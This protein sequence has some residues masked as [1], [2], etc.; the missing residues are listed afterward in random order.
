MIEISIR[1]AVKEEYKTI[2]DFQVRMALE[3]EDFM[4]D[5]QTVSKG[6]LAVFNDESKGKYY[7]A[8]DEGKIIG[9]MLTT[10]E[11]SDWR[12]KSV[13][14]LQSVFVLPEY[15]GKKV[16][17]SLYYKVKKKVDENRDKYGGIRLYVDKTNTHARNVYSKIGMTD[18]HYIF[19][20]DMS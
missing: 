2:A 17:S 14:W 11:W 1:E 15:R 12:N 5:Y 20:E 3:T 18:E 8:E 9:T 19:F 10:Y 16:F 7:I 13:I 4:L 6:I